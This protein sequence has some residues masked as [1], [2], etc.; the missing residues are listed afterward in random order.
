MK[1]KRIVLGIAAMV[2]VVLLTIMTSVMTVAGT[3][4]DPTLTIAKCNLSF[5]DSIAIKYA[6]QTTGDVTGTLLTEKT[7]STDTSTGD[8]S[9][10]NPSS[11][12]K[13]EIK[14]STGDITISISK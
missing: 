4:V 14:T 2:L 5:R 13:C 3:N 10:P 11:G 12:G 9:V 8:V 6:V 1:T 7:F